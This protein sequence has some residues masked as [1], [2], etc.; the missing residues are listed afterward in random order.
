MLSSLYVDGGTW[1]HR[2]AVKPKL[3]LLLVFGLALALVDTAV[4]LAPAAL[5]TGALY[6]SLGLGFRQAFRRLRPVLFTIAFLGVVNVFVLSPAEALVLTLRLLAIL[7]L[8]ASITATTRI[9]AFMEA[10]AD[11]AHPLERIGLIKANDV[12][13]AFGLVLR[14]VP[15]IANRYEALK[16]AHLA[17]GLV[18]K[19]HKILGPL[20]ISTLKDADS[21]AEAIDARG[22]R[23]Q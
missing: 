15:E 2:M 9:A 22:I 21:I 6:L 14:F 11:L 1:L 3:G 5:L 16:A 13:L 18:A 20:I 17:R 19:P 10:I 7:F 12:G 4:I 23:G 8:A